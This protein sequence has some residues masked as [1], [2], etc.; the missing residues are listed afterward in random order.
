MKLK[1]VKKKNHLLFLISKSRRVLSKV[2]CLE[3]RAKSNTENPNVMSGF[4]QS[5]RK[6]AARKKPRIF[7]LYCLLVSNVFFC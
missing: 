6:K 3:M 1:A 5:E 7:L 2:F 4:S